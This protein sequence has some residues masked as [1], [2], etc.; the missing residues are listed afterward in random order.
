VL[1]AT[2]KETDRGRRYVDAAQPSV[3]RD[4]LRLP[5]LLVNALTLL[6]N[7]LT[8]LVNALTLLRHERR[9]NLPAAA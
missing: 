4:G 1:A 8:L 6:V 5:P 3:D 2:T 7:A 9:D